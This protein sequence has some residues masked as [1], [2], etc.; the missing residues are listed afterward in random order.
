MRTLA[1]TAALIAALAAAQPASVA[2][3]RSAPPRTL[4][5]VQR[6]GRV[7]APGAGGGARGFTYGADPFRAGWHRGADLAAAPGARVRAACP[8]VVATARAG[9][10]G[11]VTLRCAAVARHPPAAVS[12]WR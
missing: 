4:A 12:P 2:W 1:L 8:G 10:A 5:A 9:A 7:A 3:R 11:V 6:G